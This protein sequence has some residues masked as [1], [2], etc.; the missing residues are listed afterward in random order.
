MPIP[1]QA[2]TFDAPMDPAEILDYEIKLA[3]GTVKLLEDGETAASYT[4]TLYPEAV[5]LGLNIKT[6]GGYDPTND[7]SIIKV[8]FDIDVGEQLNE[9]FD[10]GGARL[11]MELTVTTSNNPARKRQRTLVLEVLQL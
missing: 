1:A 8:W 10:G 11:A 4:L 7:G 5:L 6:G 3:D 2:F 9:A